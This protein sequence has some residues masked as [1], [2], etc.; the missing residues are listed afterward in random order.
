MIVEFY[1]V[2][3]EGFPQYSILECSNIKAC[4]NDAGCASVIAYSGLSD[5]DGVERWI[6]GK[7]SDIFYDSSNPP[8]DVCRVYNSSGKLIQTITNCQIK[9]H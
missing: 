4:F 7:E 1:K 8:Y 5:E 3:N 2:T 9:Y 6:Y